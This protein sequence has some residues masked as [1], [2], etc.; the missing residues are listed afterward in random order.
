MADCKAPQEDYVNT[1]DWLDKNCDRIAGHIEAQQNHALVL[2]ELISGYNTA[3]AAAAAIEHGGSDFTPATIDATLEDKFVGLDLSTDSM[4]AFTA[5][6]GYQ[7]G[8]D[9]VKG[10]I[11][12]ARAAVDSVAPAG[13]EGPARTALEKAKGDASHLL[14]GLDKKVT[15]VEQVKSRLDLAGRQYQAKIELDAGKRP[16]TEEELMAKVEEI[17]TPRGSASKAQ[18]EADLRKENERKR[19]KWDEAQTAITAGVGVLIDNPNFLGKAFREQCFIQ[20]N[21]FHLTGMR[22][23]GGFP[24]KTVL[25]FGATPYASIMAADI[26]PFGF[27]N[28]LTQAST[29]QALFD[30]GPEVVSQLQ[31]YVQLYKI[32][33]NPGA[34]HPEIEVPISFPSSAMAGEI[35]EVFTNKRRRGFG[36]GLK[37]F[38]WIYDGSS[39]FAQKKSI[40][41]KLT[42]F[43]ATFAELLRP[44]ASAV[45]DQSFRY[46]DLALKTGKNPLED[47]PVC[48][49]N[50]QNAIADPTDTLDFRLKAVVGYAIP[51]RLAVSRQNR[52]VLEDALANSFVTLQLT[53]TIHD[54]EF[55]ETGRVTFTI[56]YLAYI[57]ENFDDSYYDIFSVGREKKIRSYTEMI[58]KRCRPKKS[59]EEKPTPAPSEDAHLLK[60]EQV[61]NLASLLST[62]FKSNKMYFIK[63]PYVKLNEATLEPGAVMVAYDTNAAVANID[64]VVKETSRLTSEKRA[65]KVEA[66]KASLQERIDSLQAAQAGLKEGDIYEQVTFF[67]LYDLIDIILDG[68]GSCIS[69]WYPEALNALSKDATLSA[70]RKSKVIS[71]ERR[72]LARMEANFD[73]LRILLGPLEIRDPNSPNSY[74][75]VSIGEIPISNKYFIEWMTD[76]MLASERSGFTLTAFLNEFI[77]TYLRNFLNDNSCHG[78]KTRQKTALFS[79]SITSYGVNGREDADEI[80]D[81]LAKAGFY[82]GGGT[83]GLTEGVDYLSQDV[84]NSAFRN[85]IATQPLLNTMGSRTENVIHNPGL[86]YGYNYMIYYAGRTQPKEAMTGNKSADQSRGIFHYMLGNDRGVVKNIRLDKTTARGHKELRFEQ[87]GYDGLMQLREVYNVTIDSLLLPSAF[88][89]TYLFVDPRGFAPSTQGYEYEDPASARPI[90]ADQY[91]LSRYGVGGYYMVIKTMHTIGEGVMESKIIANWVAQTERGDNNGQES[92]A[93]V[94]ENPAAGTVVKCRTRVT[95]DRAKAPAPDSTD[96]VSA[97]PDLDNWNKDLGESTPEGDPSDTSPG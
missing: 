79:T 57:E 39:P 5:N 13:Y 49:D 34:G 44:R 31:P 19:K 82:P 62:L 76:K 21:I 91:E 42:I 10:A 89:G 94:E 61:A 88:P 30:M 87:E 29:T 8:I 38:S 75:T 80:V 92:I 67:F 90:H 2:N 9:K 26:S 46:A 24:K 68:I 84:L 40:S 60:K 33:D 97:N 11:E 37:S 32:I 45:K 43:A 41:A 1:Q 3:I 74:R 86:K 20:G 73:K 72:A 51:R 35:A 47:T 27:I 48:R 22:R 25:P 95:E 36:V 53:P 14:D 70:K 69:S 7:E 58:K 6:N 12:T 17:W 64:Q 77:H 56:D 93:D 83:K 59:T 52:Q 78:D 55:D 66:E 65:T 63:I 54:F 85:N 23:T 4:G 81:L 71:A 28:K 15:Q 50:V 96:D 16:M 18:I